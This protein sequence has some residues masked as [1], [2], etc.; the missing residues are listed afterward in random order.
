M[1]TRNVCRPTKLTSLA[2]TF[3][4]SPRHLDRSPALGDIQP[5]GAEAYNA[6]QKE[7]RDGLEAARKRK[8]QAERTLP[9]RSP[10]NM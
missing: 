4:T 5:G 2:R 7:F 9:S 8:E 3:A 10:T 6:R 1:L